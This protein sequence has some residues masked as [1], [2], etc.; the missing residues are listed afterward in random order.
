MRRTTQQAEATRDRILDAAEKVF[1]ANGVSHASLE[2]IAVAAGLTR[3]AVYGHFR[4]KGDLFAAMTD[5][6]LLPMEMLVAA[7]REAGEQDPL[8]RMHKLFVF[9]FSKAATEPHNRRVLEVLFTKCE[10]T[11]DM[12]RVRE[13]LRNAARDGH[14]ML[15]RG[16]R[17]AIDK[18]QLSQDLDTARAADVVHA[19]LGGVL[20]DW[21]LGQGSIVLPRDAE[22]LADFCIGSLRISP[23]LH[24]RGT[25]A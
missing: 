18:G 15:E 8:G 7:S 21:L 23:S 14:E 5:R 16:L 13:R 11:C 3:G 20:R 19:F 9:C 17:N 12:D 24:R 10:Y 6:V 1:L 4:N 25:G 22:Y 2:A